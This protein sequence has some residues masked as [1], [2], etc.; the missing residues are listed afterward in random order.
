MQYSTGAGPS[1]SASYTP[2]G[3]VNNAHTGAPSAFAFNGTNPYLQ[4]GPPQPAGLPQPDPAATRM[5]PATAPPLATASGA[6][7][8]APGDKPAKRPYK[9][10]AKKAAPDA[11]DAAGGL[12]PQTPADIGGQGGSSDA[13]T[14]KRAKKAK[15]NAPEP[16]GSGPSQQPAPASV[17]PAAG[18]GHGLPQTAVPKDSVAY[19][20]RDPTLA[21]P[22]PRPSAGPSY[23]P[24]QPQQSQNAQAGPSHSNGYYYSVPS[25]QIADPIRSAAA[26]APPTTLSEYVSRLNAHMADTRSERT[27]DSSAYLPTGEWSAEDKASF[28]PILGRHS[29]VR[30]DLIAQETGKSEQEV[31]QYLIDLHGAVPAN[32]GRKR[33]GRVKKGEWVPGIA[34][35]AREISDGDVREEERMV[36]KLKG[37]EA[38]EAVMLEVEK[39]KGKKKM[40]EASWGAQ[41]DGPKIGTLSALVYTSIPY[42]PLSGNKAAKLLRDE[43]QMAAIEAIP[44][45][46]RTTSQIKELRRLKDKKNMRMRYRHAK[47]IEEGMTAEGIEA[48][49]GPDAIY[50]ARAGTDP[51]VLD[52]SVPNAA[53]VDP[54]K[55]NKH[56]KIIRD[57]AR[58]AHLNGLKHPTREEIAETRRLLNKKRARLR[59]RRMKLLE[60]GMTEQQLAGINIDELYAKRAGVAWVTDSLA[61]DNEVIPG[62]AEWA[63]G[64]RLGDTHT[65]VSFEVLQQLRIYL[66]AYLV[67]LI[68]KTINLAEKERVDPSRAHVQLLL[69]VAEEEGKLEDVE[70]EEGDEWE[71]DTTTTDREERELDE[72]L[73]EVDEE[74]DRVREE[75]GGDWDD[76][77]NVEGGHSHGGKAGR[78]K[79]REYLVLLNRYTLMQSRRAIKRASGVERKRKSLRGKNKLSA[80]IIEDSDS[81]EEVVGSETTSDSDSEEEK[82]DSEEGLDSEADDQEGSQV[83]EEDSPADEQGSGEDD[84]S[85]G[86]DIEGMLSGSDMDDD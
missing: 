3:Q 28:F 65:Q 57:E 19:L 51:V 22:P 77:F 37:V 58:L 5:D 52:P 8:A 34:L 13:P 56:G 63:I 54:L 27:G 40:T 82:G 53:Q 67:P 60:E 16:A 43:H 7:A 72:L 23:R 1:G 30:P 49:G 46:Q 31:Q 71:I 83:G 50:L 9:K 12:L 45:R 29:T 61:E 41:L 10:R 64:R 25:S 21:S 74:Y 86:Q 26:A 14:R 20:Y 66:L 33:A 73:D 79:R 35:A 42:D 68:H 39:G 48:Q 70:D 2:Q 15:E 62:L 11:N 36:E 59:I 69:E 75:E 32:L 6:A 81:E 44:I 4:A 47:L 84:G 78:A 76:P 24:P 80:A 85:D 18:I 38:H 55:G 17:G